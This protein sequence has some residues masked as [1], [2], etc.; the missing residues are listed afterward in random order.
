MSRDGH[1]AQD[2]KEVSRDGHIELEN[3]KSNELNPNNLKCLSKYWVWFGSHFILT[4]GM[5]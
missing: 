5:G 1:M 3:Q 2:K 4:R